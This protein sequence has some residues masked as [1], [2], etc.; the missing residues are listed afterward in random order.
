MAFAKKCTFSQPPPAQLESKSLTVSSW[1]LVPCFG[2]GQV[3]ACL[4]WPLGQPNGCIAC[5]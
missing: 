1:R 2:I 5:S 3:R 4:D